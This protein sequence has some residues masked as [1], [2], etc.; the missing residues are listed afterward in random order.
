MRLFILEESSNKSKKYV[1]YE[2]YD[3]GNTG[4]KVNFGASGYEDY[5]MHSDAERKQRYIDRHAKRENWKK[6]GI[7]TAGFWSRWLLWNKPSLAGSI[8][9]TA[10]RFGIQIKNKT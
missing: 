3:D 8:R 1:I 7:S 5:T 2:K 4:K 10:S 9:D 6:S